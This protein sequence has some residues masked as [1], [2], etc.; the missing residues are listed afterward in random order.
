VVIDT[1]SSGVLQE[2][3]IL[4]ADVLVLTARVE[5]LGVDGVAAA[6]GAAAQ[7]AP[8]TPLVVAPVAYDR[9]LKEHAANLAI[10]RGAFL[11]VAEPIPARV[12]VAE[13]QACGLTCYEMAGG[14]AVADAYGAL[15]ALV[16]GAV[17]E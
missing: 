4:A 8:D 12:V 6:S 9:R 14:N 2:A 16:A 7:L 3:A 15:L 5:A 1:A 11:R 10:L 17:G 13:A